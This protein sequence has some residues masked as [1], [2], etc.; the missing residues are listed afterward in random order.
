MNS[1]REMLIYGMGIFVLKGL[2]FIMMP[3]VTRMLTQVDYGELN[4]LVSIASMVSLFL[5]LGLGD[6][7][8]R[9]ASGQVKE[10][11]DAVMRQC[12]RL[13]LL[14]AVTFLCLALPLS[15]LIMSWLPVSLGLL[16]L[17][18]LLI[19]LS[20]SSLLTVPYCY[21]RM[22]HRAVPFMVF[23]I[24]Q[25][26][27]Q[28]ML[29]IGLLLSGY[30]VTGMMLS[31]AISSSVIAITVLIYFRAHLQGTRTQFSLEHYRYI[32]FIVCSGIFVYCLN[33]AENWL[34]VIHLGKQQLAIF[35][36]AGQ[37]GLMI[38]V[39]FEPFRMW[40]YARRFKIHEADP[41]LGAKYAVLG[42]QI[43]MILAGSM[44]FFAPVLM[45]VMLPESYRESI[46]L[47]PWIC[48][49]MALRFHSELLNIGC[50]LKQSARWASII[51]GVCAVHLVAV[52]Y[53]AVGEHGLTGLL[54]TM[55]L[56][57]L[58]RGILFYMISQR[59]VYLPYRKSYL[60]TSWG[61]FMILLIVN[62]SKISGYRVIE[63]ILLV[64][65][66]LLLLYFYRDLWRGLQ[67]SAWRRYISH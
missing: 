40:W 37:F 14:C 5:T 61:I 46:S 17:Q 27:L 51:D 1:L 32:A 53:W 60:L 44:L 59:L 30:G 29:S 50:F 35:F 43:G 15:G 52:G 48:L 25:G 54:C 38:S 58:I 64:I 9:F 8:F 11:N 22:T 63:F 24:A 41:K 21:F 13:S 23:S 39:A 12:F 36:A 20:L 10:D 34:V 45:N 19:S 18:L 62:M 4:F 26:A 65:N 55:V 33:G 3:I 16:D 42:V 2:G 28:T 66:S 7:L 31:S 56:T 47:I 6:I 49:I 57:V 67:L